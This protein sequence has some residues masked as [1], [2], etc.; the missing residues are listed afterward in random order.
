MQVVITMAGLGQRFS[1][2]SF[3]DPKPFVKLDTGDYIIEKLVQIFPSEWKIIFVV[4]NTLDE[5]YLNILK[6][7]RS[8]SHIVK[9][10]YSE[11]GPIDTVK[12]ALDFIL[13][14]P[15]LISYCDYSLIWDAQDFKFQMESQRADCAIIGYQGVHPTYFGPNSYCHYQVEN[16]NVI[17]LQ[18]KMFFTDH[19]F[20][21]WTSCGLY[22]FK[23]KSILTEALKE[24]EK[25]NLNY[26]GKEFYTSLA[27]K[28][29]MNINPNLKV[30]NYSVTHFLQ[31]GTPFDVEQYNYWS[32]FFTNRT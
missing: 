18:E 8:D 28:A 9:V 5:K 11:R 16:Q 26:K 32:K 20:K 2:Q 4:A 13:D 31:L 10:S 14:Q 19:F 12:T 29:L 21:E 23:N 1:E 27:I 25:Q 15:I 3:K 17:S 24:Q 7:I 6:K 30:L 22:Y